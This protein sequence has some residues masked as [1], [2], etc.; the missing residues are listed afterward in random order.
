MNNSNPYLA[1][2]ENMPDAMLL[3][4]AKAGKLLACNEAALTL[5][6][7]PDKAALLCQTLIAL[8]PEFQVDGLS[9]SSMAAAMLTIVMQKGF[10]RFDWQYL[11]YDGSLVLVEVTLTTLTIDNEL[12]FQLALKFIPIGV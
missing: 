9:S 11:R 8:S 5:L 6:A 10:H 7:Y 4:G 2:L 12:L 1:Q 3:V